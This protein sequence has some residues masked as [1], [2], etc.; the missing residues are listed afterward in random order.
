MLKSKRSLRKGTN[1]LVQVDR[2]IESHPSW[3]GEL[4]L[5]EAA[6]LLEGNNPF[7]YVVT[8]GFDKYHYFL[9]YV[10]AD[11]KV[12]HRNVRST[13]K[14]EKTFYY[15]GGGG[16]G[17]NYETIENLVPGCLNCSATICRPL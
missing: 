1:K 13:I 6:K 15:N 9:T 3:R 14:N 5:A 12:K 17:G 7:T 4:T 16:T 8:Q 11:Q 10:D 2:G